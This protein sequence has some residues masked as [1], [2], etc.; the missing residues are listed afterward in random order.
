MASEYRYH[1]VSPSFWTDRKVMSWDDDARLLAL[2]IMT[3]EHRTTEGLFRLPKAYICADIGWTPERLEIPF[4]ILLRDGFIQYDETV[5]VMLLTN[6]LKWNPTDNDKHAMGAAKSLVGLPETPLLQEFIQLAIRYDKRL[7]KQLEERYGIQQALTLAQTQAQEQ[8]RAGARE[9]DDDDAQD[10]KDFEQWF[11]QAF[12]GTPNKAH[13]DEVDGFVADGMA[14]KAIVEAVR[15]AA[16]NKAQGWSYVRRIVQ[17][18][19]KDEIYTLEQV[20]D[21]KTDTNPRA[22]PDDLPEGLSNALRSARARLQ[23]E[24]VKDGAVT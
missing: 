6:A 14:L 7:A 16:L 2:Y 22:S 18:W 19:I 5:A 17:N 23:R 24:G 13:Y 15:L 21:R 20:R 12:G 1:K 10:R 8:E 9:D 4:A 11:A 3:C